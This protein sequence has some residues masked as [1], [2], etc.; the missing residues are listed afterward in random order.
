MSKGMDK[1]QTNKQFLIL[2]GCIALLGILNLLNASN[3]P[4]F[5]DNFPAGKPETNIYDGHV[6]A[7]ITYEKSGN[8]DYT[9]VGDTITVTTTLEKLDDGVLADNYKQSSLVCIF[10]DQNQAL[11]LLEEPTL[12]YT[13]AGIKGTGELLAANRE[14]TKNLLLFAN[15]Y[16]GW[17]IGEPSLFSGR[18]TEFL[19]YTTDGIDDG[20]Y[21]DTYSVYNLLENKGDSM[22]I[23][24]QAKVTEEV[25]KKDSF[26]LHAAVYDSV[27]ENYDVANFLTAEMPKFQ[28]QEEALSLSFDSDCHNKELT[29]E[30]TTLTG[31]WTGSLENITPRLTINSI[32]LTDDDLLS[33]FNSDGTFSIPIDLRKIPNQAESNV[34]TLIIQEESGLSAQ[35]T[36]VLKVTKRDSPPVIELSENLEDQTLYLYPDDQGF[37]LRGDWEAESSHQINLFYKLNG[38]EKKLN[39][40]E[41][42]NTSPGTTV[43]F[44]RKLLLADLVPGENHF[45]VYAIDE[46]NQRSNVETFT[47]IKE[48]GTV[49]FSNVPDRLLFSSIPIAGTTIQSKLTQAFNLLVEDTTEKVGSWKLTVR[50]MDDFKDND[51]R[52]P[53]TLY[54]QN[55]ET[56]QVFSK[57]QPI[58]IP[59][60]ETEDES[61]DHQYMILQNTENY[62][63]LDVQP[64]G[65]V[66]EYS[67]ELEW[68]IV[69]AP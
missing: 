24:Y 64:G 66:G 36:A 40:S 13:H 23:T 65:Y 16:S 7:K 59:V 28:S 33:Y 29:S 68:T 56:K 51:K 2:I 26:E 60:T 32:N 17:N 49:K 53:A 30:Q 18:I 35:D 52:L 27:K 63:A 19:P 38:V 62:F 12:T 14:L 9:A 41:V 45:E 1:Q 37:T 39:D 4:V 20:P 47:V 11:Q 22:R 55:K 48:E 44:S 21:E 3:K 31:K 61:S 15:L 42:V 10:P 67:S 58:T 43:G 57:D 34:V 69:N 46:K 50:Q 5:A 6:K 25:Q 8:P 54:Y